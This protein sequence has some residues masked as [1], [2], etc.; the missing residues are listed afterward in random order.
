MKMAINLKAI[1][2]KFAGT[3]EGRALNAIDEQTAAAHH[4]ETQAWETKCYNEGISTEEFNRVRDEIDRKYGFT[5]TS[6]RL[7]NA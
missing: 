4:A 7:A 3:E 1:A 6:E 5:P 2:A